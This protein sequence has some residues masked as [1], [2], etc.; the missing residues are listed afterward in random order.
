MHLEGLDG[1]GSPSTLRKWE[2]GEKRPSGPSLKL[3]NLLERKG[4]AAI[5]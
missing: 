4:L 5:L 1:R 3:L 2:I